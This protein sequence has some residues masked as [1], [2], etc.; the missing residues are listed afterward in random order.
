MGVVVYNNPTSS[1]SRNIDTTHVSCYKK[2]KRM[3]RMR[4]S[5]NRS[6]RSTTLKVTPRYARIL[7]DLGFK[8]NPRHVGV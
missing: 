4:K 7:R 1:S 8:V 3:S 2:K 6:L 5:K